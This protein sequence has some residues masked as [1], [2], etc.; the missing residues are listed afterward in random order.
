MEEGLEFVARAVL[1]GAG[2]T[3]VLDLW[4]LVLKR[5]AGLP[6]PNWGLV[7][8]WLGHFPRGRFKH[9]NIARAAPIRGERAIGWGAHYVIGILFAAVLLVLWGLDWAHR[10]T[11]L[12][13]L[14][15]GVGTV[16]APFLLMQPG[17]GSGVAASK[18]PNPT[19]ARLR[20]L[21]AHTVFGLGLYGAAVLVASLH[22]G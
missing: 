22:G 8:R 12:P 11:L 4:T 16:A 15:V 17:M 2:A 7:G 5:V 14:V 3:V 13:A 10:P 1:I 9:D 21:M 19:Q 20:S 18:T 6:G